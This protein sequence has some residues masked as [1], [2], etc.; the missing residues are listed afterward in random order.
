MRRR[1][2]P[3]VS[4]FL[5]YRLRPHVASQPAEHLVENAVDPKEEGPI[6]IP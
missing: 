2:N 4:Q 6:Y 5:Q 3:V 1:P